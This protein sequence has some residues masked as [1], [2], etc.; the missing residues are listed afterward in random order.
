M[1]NCNKLPPLG[2]CG[3]PQPAHLNP[4]KCFQP[5]CSVHIRPWKLWLGSEAAVAA[6]AAAP[7]WPFAHKNRAQIGPFCAFAGGTDGNFLGLQ[8]FPNVNTLQ[9]KCFEY[10]LTCVIQ[11]MN[12]WE[13]FNDFVWNYGFYIYIRIFSCKTCILTPP[14]PMAAPTEHRNVFHDIKLC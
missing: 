9:L 13:F 6:V 8:H 2:L 1:R 14:P 10:M 12:C 7:K 4:T 3:N 5:L 11:Y